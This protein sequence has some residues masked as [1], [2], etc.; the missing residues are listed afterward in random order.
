MFL[1]CIK[2][3]LVKYEMCFTTFGSFNKQMAIGNSTEN[4]WL[5]KMLSVIKIKDQNETIEKQ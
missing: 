5:Q 2:F 3:V 1:K 4:G